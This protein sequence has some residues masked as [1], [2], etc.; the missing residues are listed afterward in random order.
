MARS[1]TFSLS[2]SYTHTQGRPVMLIDPDLER[3]LALPSRQQNHWLFL[4][5]SGSSRVIGC[6]LRSHSQHSRI[7]VRLF[8]A[9]GDSH[10]VVQPPNSH[11]ALLKRAA[12]PPPPCLLL[13][14]GIG[15]G[16]LTHISDFAA[17]FLLRKSSPLSDMEHRSW[18]VTQ[19]GNSPQ[20]Y[21]SIRTPALSFQPRSLSPLR[22]LFWLVSPSLS[23]IL[24]VQL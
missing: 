12:S 5:V 3:S 14:T 6:F 20:S 23:C 24:L 22:L 18:M 17:T 13:H 10:H 21:N 15:E 2:L 11:H 4:C 7:S 8:G 9:C 19:A 1:L 16:L